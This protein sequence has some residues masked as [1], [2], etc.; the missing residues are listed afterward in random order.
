MISG[1][2][3]STGVPSSTNIRATLPD[4]G[5]GIWFIVFMASTIRIVC[6]SV[7]LSP[8]EIN[9]SEPGFSL[10]INSPYHW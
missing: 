6:P 10:K 2:P 9:G 5:A 1:V 7:I 3:N 4:F 8:I